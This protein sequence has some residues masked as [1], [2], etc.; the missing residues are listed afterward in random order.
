M[1]G[2]GS[3]R[4]GG[5]LTVQGATALVLDV[6]KL[7]TP[8]MLV[9]RG[10]DLPLPDI[11][12]ITLKWDVPASLFPQVVSAAPPAAASALPKPGKFIST[13]IRCLPLVM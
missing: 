9:L 1:G 5:R 7:M 2:S 6:N 4:S 10:R 3:G 12:S 8:I 13:N 11:R